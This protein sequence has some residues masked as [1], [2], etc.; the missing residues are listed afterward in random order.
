MFLLL[1]RTVPQYLARRNGNYEDE[2]T[3]LKWIGINF[4]HVYDRIPSSSPA[5]ETDAHYSLTMQQYVW[6]LRD[7]SSTEFVTISK[8]DAS[9]CSTNYI[10]SFGPDILEVVTIIIPW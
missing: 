3:N 8:Y 7:M 9:F 10:C 1:S 5:A 2:R 6:P 4:S